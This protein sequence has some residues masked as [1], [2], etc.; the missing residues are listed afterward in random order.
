[1]GRTGLCPD[2]LQPPPVL[3]LSFFYV[4]TSGDIVSDY[5]FVI[6]FSQV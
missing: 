5:S 1:M 3:T 6:V 2:N 4:E